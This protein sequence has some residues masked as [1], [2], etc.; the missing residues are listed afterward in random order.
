MDEALRWL[1]RYIL[2]RATE[3]AVAEAT[4]IGLVAGTVAGFLGASAFETVL[5]GLVAG[6]VGATLRVLGALATN[7]VSHRYL[8]EWSDPSGLLRVAQTD[9]QGSG[10]AGPGIDQRQPEVWLD[11]ASGFRFMLRLDLPESAGGVDLF[12][13][14]SGQV[15]VI[16]GDRCGAGDRTLGDRDLTLLSKLSDGRLVVTSTALFPPRAGLLVNQVDSGQMLRL[17]ASHRE[18]LIGLVAGGASVTPTW[19]ES[20]TDLFRLEW[21]GWQDLGPFAGPLVAVQPSGSDW[22]RLQVQVPPEALWRHGATAPV[23]HPNRTADRVP[24]RDVA[25]SGSG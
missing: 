19:P 10:E 14:I 22:A 18:R 11:G 20:V 21:E 12:R 8:L 7:P 25:R 6:P 1:R 4:V 16:A 24:S 2:V 17:V 3:R 5:L 15:M 23:P 9:Q 13:H